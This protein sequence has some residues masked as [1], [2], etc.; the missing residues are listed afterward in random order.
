M[1]GID[2]DADGELAFAR[3]EVGRHRAERFTKDDIGAPVQKPDRLRVALDGHRGHGA[4]DRE[5]RELD[6]HF[7]TEGTRTACAHPFEGIH[8]LLRHTSPPRGT[9]GVGGAL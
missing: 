5:L 8:R 4:L 1:R 2:V 9:P 3:P 7:L 6:A